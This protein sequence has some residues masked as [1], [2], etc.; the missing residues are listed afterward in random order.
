MSEFDVHS[1]AEE[2]EEEERKIEGDIEEKRKSKFDH[3]EDIFSLKK[4]LFDLNES[5]IDYALEEICESP[6]VSSIDSIWDLF[7][8]IFHAVKFRYKKHQCYTTLTMNLYNKREEIPE[9]AVIK[10]ILI[11]KFHRVVPRC[12]L[13][14][15]DIFYFSYLYKCFTQFLLSDE[16][17]AT[18]LGIFHH[19]HPGKMNQ[20][21]FMCLWF[22]PELEKYNI[23]LFDKIINYECDKFRKGIPRFQDDDCVAKF[24]SKEMLEKLRKNNWSLLKETI[25]TAYEP[26]SIGDAIRTDNIE[27]VKDYVNRS[28]FNINSTLPKSPFLQIPL[29]NS[30]PTLIHAAAYFS[31]TKS[32]KFLLLNNA[33]PKLTDNVGKTLSNFAVAGGCGEIIRICEQLNLPFDNTITFALQFHQNDILEWILSSNKSKSS[34]QKLLCD[35]SAFGN[36]EFLYDIL[37]TDNFFS[38]DEVCMEIYST[39]DLLSMLQKVSIYEDH[40]EVFE[41]TNLFIEENM[42]REIDLTKIP[43]KGEDDGDNEYENEDINEFENEEIKQL[44][45]EKLLNGDINM[46][47]IED[48]SEYENEDLEEDGNEKLQSKFLISSLPKKF[49]NY[50]LFVCAINDSIRIC[51]YIISNL[52]D[53]QVYFNDKRNNAINKAARNGHDDVLDLLL[54]TQ[55]FDVNYL[56]KNNLDALYY[57]VSDGHTSTT[58]ILLKHGAQ[59]GRTSLKTNSFPIHLAAKL[60]FT[61]ILALLLKSHPDLNLIDD[62][63][64]TPLQQAAKNGRTEAIQMLLKVEYLNPNFV[65]NVFDDRTPLYLAC[66]YGFSDSV[67]EL[68]A[69][70]YIQINTK[71]QGNS[72]PILAATYKRSF[73]IVKILLDTKKVIVN[74]KNQDQIIPLHIA[75][76]NGDEDIASA[77]VDYE[78]ST[79]VINDGRGRLPIHIA[80]INGHVKI[81]EKLLQIPEVVEKINEVDIDKRTP[82]H[83][84]AMIPKN[85]L[86]KLLLTIK[87]IDVNA[88]DN[89]GNTPLMYASL[90]GN[91]YNSFSLVHYKYED[92]NETNSNEGSSNETNNSKKNSKNINILAVNNNNWTALHFAAHKDNDDIVQLLLPIMINSSLPDSVNAKTINGYTAVHLAVSQ[93]A[94]NSLRILLKES[95]VDVN[96]RSSKKKT[97]LHF[98]A[99]Y[100]FVAGAKM[101]LQR[102]DID[103]NAEDEFGLT[104]LKLALKYSRSSVA[105]LINPT[106][107]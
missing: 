65:N 15:E 52:E 56:N 62:E 87:E 28:D 86:L 12:I 45:I 57:A 41:I 34:I 36:I 51:K 25:R 88:T 83:Y 106:E 93:K 9:L 58:E 63:N 102:D 82:L 46:F 68:I 89:E 50:Q 107:L 23:E 19:N 73:P 29:L 2:D 38:S 14:T 39:K 64:L 99:M 76:R 92:D 31:S 20:L 49:Y 91:Y 6:F 13:P 40:R 21:R 75:C 70:Q 55:L 80:C 5:S 35:A 54:S 66:E 67:K 59:F 69:H 72:T 103:I 27:L 10:D 96:A 42:N 94:E 7:H 11:F 105:N 30:S 97:P 47:D 24:Y 22:L 78:P 53:K 61:P 79:S 74:E 17:I 4:L 95:T 90:Y 26:D 98:A 60:N 81:V 71:C 33:N 77:L 44:F 8:H 32:F 48:I 85:N 3:L 37:F 18:E 104:P 84:S 101:L 100:G 1:H 16:E 43:K